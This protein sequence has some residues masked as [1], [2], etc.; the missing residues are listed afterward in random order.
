LPTEIEWKKAARG[1][2]GR[3]FHQERDMKKLIQRDRRADH[4]RQIAR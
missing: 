3:I 1:S 2:D 4:F